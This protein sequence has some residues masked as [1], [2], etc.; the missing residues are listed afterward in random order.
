MFPVT[1]GL[2]QGDALSPALFNIALESV[3]RTVISQAKGIEIKDNQHLT[4]VVYADD[5]VLLAETVN[6]LKNTTDILLK[7]GKKLV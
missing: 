1:T 4:T 2:R 7:E 6:D 5:I 3:M